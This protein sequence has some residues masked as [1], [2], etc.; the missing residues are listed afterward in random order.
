MRYSFVNN[1]YP[2]IKNLVNKKEPSYKEYLRSNPVGQR[3]PAGTGSRDLAYNEE[4][5]NTLDNFIEYMKA[6][7]VTKIIYVA[8]LSNFHQSVASYA[9]LKDAFETVYLE[10]SNEDWLY[11]NSLWDWLTKSF[12]PNAYYNKQSRWYASKFLSFVEFCDREYGIDVSED[13]IWCTPYP[14]AR[15]TQIYLDNLVQLLGEKG[16]KKYSLHIYPTSFDDL[17]YLK[18]RQKLLPKGFKVY[19]TE[20]NVDYGFDA[21]NKTNDNIAWTTTHHDLITQLLEWCNS[22]MEEVALHYGVSE[23]SDNN[24]AAVVV[25]GGKCIKRLEN[26]LK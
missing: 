10:F 13:I 23:N 11:P 18:S 15:H 14:S 25:E 4:Y 9:L 8:N 6:A 20:V 7:G 24:Y 1:V 19:G 22:F 26:F 21:G 3:F 12:N 16:F 5:L 17:E 2:I